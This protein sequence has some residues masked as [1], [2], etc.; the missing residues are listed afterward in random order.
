M[1]SPRAPPF[2][3]RA[4]APA[5]KAALPRER[6]SNRPLF[7]CAPFAKQKGGRETLPPLRKLDERYQAE[8]PVGGH[9]GAKAADGVR[10]DG[11]ADEL[12]V[13]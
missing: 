2:V 10:G 11:A 4:Q 1:P 13:L 6:R 7:A 8:Q 12:A 5:A 3:G 9:A